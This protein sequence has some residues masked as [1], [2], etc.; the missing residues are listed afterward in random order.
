MPAIVPF[1][2]MPQLFANL[3][4]YFSGQQRTALRYKDRNTKLWVDIPWEEFRDRVH[5]MAGFLHESGVRPGDRVAILSEN[6]PEWAVTD[7][8]TQILGGVNVSLYTSL[9]PA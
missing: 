1:D 5:A 9:P 3:A 6:R 2:T 8:A 7:M 4:T